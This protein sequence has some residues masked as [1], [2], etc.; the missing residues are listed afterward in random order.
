MTRDGFAGSRSFSTWCGWG[1]ERGSAAALA[2]ALRKLSDAGNPAGLSYQLW[3]LA[4][5]SSLPW[6]DRV[7]TP[8]LIVS[9]TADDL[10][11]PANAVRLAACCRTAVCTCFPAG[12]HQVVSGA[13]HDQRRRLDSVE[14]R[15]AR[16]G[17]ERPELV[18]EAGRVARVAQ[19]AECAGERGRRPSFAAPA[20]PRRDEREPANPSRVIVRELLC[21]R[22]AERVPE[23]VDAR[24]AER[25]ENAANDPRERR[26]RERQQR[27]VGAAGAGR[28]EDDRPGAPGEHLL[29]TTH[30]SA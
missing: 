19:L 17:G 12:D 23:H 21:D 5:W 15:Q 8:T 29:G 1:G 2:R 18:R 20:A 25:L 7:E 16:P 9:G 4:A 14:P 22:A 27:Q 3:S 28:V 13:R 24:V 10:V 11:P 30:I 6:L 26:D